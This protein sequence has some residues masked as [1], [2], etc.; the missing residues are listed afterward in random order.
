LVLYLGQR[1]D[2]IINATQSRGNYWFRVGTGGGRCDGPNANAA[3]IRSIFRYAGAE[4]ANP[5][6]AANVTLPTGCYDENFVPWVKTEVPQDL[7]KELEVGFTATAGSGNL[8]QWLVNG[9]PMLI[10][11]DRPT[12]QAVSEGNSTW[13]PG[14]Q[15]F[16]ISEAHQVSTQL[17][18]AANQPS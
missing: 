10:D 1:Y 9:I 18:H 6:S 16:I 15:V 7:P 13:T 3:N 17:P 2:V 12:L 5:D 11:F 8:V 4:I 14:E